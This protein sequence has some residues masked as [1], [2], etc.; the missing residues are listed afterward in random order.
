MPTT[1]PSPLVLWPGNLHN[2]VLDRLTG[3]GEVLGLRASW[4]SQKFPPGAV[5]TS[6]SDVVGGCQPVDSV[7][8]IKFY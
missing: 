5:T 6:M 7:P 1:K 3:T 8:D 2:H 4:S